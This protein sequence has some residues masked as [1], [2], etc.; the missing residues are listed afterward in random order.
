MSELSSSETTMV[1]YFMT[2]WEETPEFKEIF[3][4]PTDAEKKQKRIKFVMEHANYIGIL[5]RPLV[6]IKA[7][8][9][10]NEAVQ[11]LLSSA[12]KLDDFKI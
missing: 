4:G 8:E 10:I 2:E 12:Q 5:G 9:N 11:Q 7:G 6:E 3:D 1:H